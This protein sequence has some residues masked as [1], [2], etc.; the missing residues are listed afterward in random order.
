MKS[1]VKEEN[2]ANLPLGI[3]KCAL[4]LSVRQ[5]LRLEDG[6]MEIDSGG[7]NSFAG[8]DFRSTIIG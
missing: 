5:E 4:V 8:S 1:A 2:R 6:K 3:V 7:R